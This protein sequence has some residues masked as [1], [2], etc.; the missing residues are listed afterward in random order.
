M[1]VD[2]FPSPVV[3]VVYPLMSW[4]GVM[5][6]GYAFGALYRMDAGQRDWWLWYL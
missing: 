3:L 2:G 1:P 6:A 5:A 4:I